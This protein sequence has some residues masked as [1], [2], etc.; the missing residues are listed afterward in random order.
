MTSYLVP[1]NIGFSG[2]SPIGLEVTPG[3]EN[4]I[5]RSSTTAACCGSGWGAGAGGGYQIPSLRLP[6]RS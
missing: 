6:D 1:E 2:L 3:I 4:T 5:L